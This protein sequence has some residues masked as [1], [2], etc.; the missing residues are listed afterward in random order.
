MVR[1]L[2]DEH[3]LQ[4]LVLMNDP[5]YLE[6]ARKFAEPLTEVAA[7]PRTASATPTAWHWAARPGTRSCGYSGCVRRAPPRIKDPQGREEAAKCRRVQAERSARPRGP[8][9]LDRHRKPDPERGR[10]H[11]EELGQTF[12]KRHPVLQ[13][14]AGTATGLLGIPAA[15]APVIPDRQ[16]AGTLEPIRKEHDLPALAAALVI[17]GRP[18]AYG[19]VGVRKYGDGTRVTPDDRFHL[20]SCTKAM[21]AT[22]IAMLIERGKLSWDTTLAGAFPE[23]AAKMHPDRASVTLEMLL[24]H[25]GGFPGRRVRRKGSRSWRCT[26]FRAIRGS[27]RRAYVEL[28]LRETPECKPGEKFI[29]SNAGFTVAGTIAERTARRPYETLIAEELFRPLGITT[30]GFGAMGVPGRMGRPWRRRP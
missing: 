5:T 17:D 18:A 30:A 22:L 6:A 7:L 16:D 1:P 23:L 4:A 20:G 21:T 29:Y 28:F 9:S 11:L 10:D 13:V 2:R 25:R 19:A 27:K 24:A 3:P 26:G 15:A 8:G 14:A 12:L